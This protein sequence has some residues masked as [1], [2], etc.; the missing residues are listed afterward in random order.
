MDIFILVFWGLGVGRSKRFSGQEGDKFLKCCTTFQRLIPSQPLFSIHLLTITFHLYV[1]SINT[2]KKI[3]KPRVNLM[4]F[5]QTI[6]ST[7]KKKK[8]YIHNLICALRAAWWY[9]FIPWLQ[10]F[11]VLS[12]HQILT[13][14]IRTKLSA[15]YY[16]TETRAVFQV[17]YFAFK[18]ALNLEKPEVNFFMDRHIKNSKN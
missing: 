11:L 16:E 14:Y 8:I 6:I 17:V 5:I 2:E 12:V 13:A 4:C 1:Q 9:F 15:K 18:Q 7:G 10:V 3:T